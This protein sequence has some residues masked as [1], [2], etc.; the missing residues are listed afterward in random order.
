MKARIERKELEKVKKEIGGVVEK[1][2]LQW[3]LNL[4]KVSGKDGKLEVV[5]SNYDI[6]LY[7]Y[8]DCELDEPGAFIVDGKLFPKI[9]SS[10]QGDIV[11]LTTAET[12]VDLNCGKSSYR[13]QF[14]GDAEEFPQP[15]E[16]RTKG[17]TFEITPDILEKGVRSVSFCCATEDI[18][19]EFTGVLI[20]GGE[21]MGNLN[22]VASDCSILALST[23]PIDNPFHGELLVPNQALQRLLNCCRG[24]DK[25]KITQTTN[26]L[27]RAEVYLNDELKWQLISRSITRPF[28]NYAQVIP[29]DGFVCNVRVKADDLLKAIKRGTVLEDKIDHIKLEAKEDTLILTNKTTEGEFKEELPADIEGSGVWAFNPKYLID[30]LSIILNSNN[31]A[32]AILKLRGQTE[33]AIIESKSLPEWQCI[34][35]PMDIPEYF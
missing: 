17:E 9:I 13:L 18:R 14:P 2:K 11:E 1:R 10:V 22:F 3:A 8:L 34:I 6:W 4:I 29:C 31:K 25:V 24:A 7:G 30:T 23:F 32:E 19:P 15:E 5:G 33:S 35:M 16:G 21:I 26:D 28:P 20:D 27:L 12:Y